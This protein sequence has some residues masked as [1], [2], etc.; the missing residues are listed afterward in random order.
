M[1]LKLSRKYIFKNFSKIKR[2]NGNVYT[3]CHVMWLL[4][5]YLPI[6]QYKTLNN[7]L[8]LNEKL[9]KLKI[10]SSPLCSFCNLEKKNIYTFFTLAIKQNHC[11]LN[12]KSYW[13]QKHFTHKIHFFGFQII[14][15]ISKL[16]TIC[17]LH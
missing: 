16:L 8:H 10:V 12:A 11:S 2:L 1:V 5:H 4:R 6:F 13:T 9:F 3:L 17:I 14:K 7:V 15:R